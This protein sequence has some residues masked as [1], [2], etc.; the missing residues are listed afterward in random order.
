MKAIAI[1]QNILTNTNK[2]VF[3]AFSLGTQRVGLVQSGSHYLI[4]N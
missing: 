2:L 4:Q 3:F 1:E